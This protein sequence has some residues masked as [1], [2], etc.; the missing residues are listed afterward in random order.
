MLK[1]KQKDNSKKA[2]LELRLGLVTIRLSVIRT[3]IQ[4]PGSRGAAVSA[5][6]LAVCVLSPRLRVSA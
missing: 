3:A 4:I 1:G 2:T 6:I 5:E